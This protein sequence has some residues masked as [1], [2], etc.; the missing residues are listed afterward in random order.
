MKQRTQEWSGAW[1]L[2]V[3]SVLV[4]CARTALTA[5]DLSF[6]S[7]DTF[8]YSGVTSGEQS[9]LLV[10]FS[11][12]EDLTATHPELRGP[13]TL[14]AVHET[15]A[16]EI[17]EGTSVAGEYDNLVSGLTLVKLPAGVSATEAMLQF[18]GSE[19]VLYAEPD[20]RYQL[21]RVPND[22][23]FKDQWNLNNTGQDGGLVDADIDAPEAWDMQT[24]KKSVIVAILDTGIDANNVDVVYNLWSNNKEVMGQPGVDDDGNGK[25]DDFAGYNFLT[26]SAAAKDLMDDAYHGT[27]VAGIIGAFTN[28]SRGIAGTCWQVSMMPLKVGDANGVN[29]SAAV[30]AIEYAVASG[31]RIINASWASTEYS[32]SLRNAIEEAGKKGVLVVAAAGNGSRNIDRLP[33]Y[34]ACYGLYNIISVLATNNRDQLASTSNYGRASVDLG[35]PGEGVLSTTPTVETPAMKA[36]GVTKNYSKLSGTSVAAP[37]V[38]AASALLWSQF[39][40]LSYYHV[41]HILMSTA[42]PVLPGLCLSQGRLNLARALKAVPQGQVGRVINTRNPSSFYFS[43]QQAIDEA[44]DGD[45]IVAE[46]KLGSTSIYPEH[47]DFKG[48]AI[49][50]RSGNPLAPDDPTIYPETTLIYGLFGEG[51]AVTFASGEGRGSVLKGF[52]VGWAM[53]VNGAGIRIEG[54]SPTI[55]QCIISNNQ[56]SDYG[57]GI[58]CFVGSPEITNCVISDNVAFGEFGVGGGL[59]FEQSEASISDCIIRN[60][61]SMNVGGGVGCLDASPTFVNCFV[62]NNAAINGSGQ[63]DLVRAS[64]TITNCTIAVDKNS[65]ARDGGI[66]AFDGS[67]PTI[68]NCILWGNGDDLVG[69]S[70]TYSCIEDID[71]V[72][73]GNIF[74]DPQFVKGPRGTYYL[75]Q[76]EAG[77]LTTSPCVD[78]GDPNTAAPIAQ[79]LHGLTTRTDGVMDTGIIDMGVHYAAGSAQSFPLTVTVVDANDQPVDA[80]EA[81]GSVSPSSGLFREYEVVQLTAQV[82]DGYRIKRWVGIGD[83]TIKDPN[84]LITVT[85][86]MDIKIEFEK[87]PVYHLITKV[88]SRNGSLQP[89]YHRVAGLYPEGTVVD[90]TASPEPTY[91]VDKWQGTDN[92]KSW[93]NDNTVTMTGDKVVTVS[94]RQGRSL[95]VPG[96]YKTIKQAIDAA[97]THGDKIIV[98]GGTYQIDYTADPSGLD[99]KGKAIVL[100]SENP[101]DPYTV[102]HTIIDCN[103]RGRAFIFQNSEGPDAVIQGFTIRNGRTNGQVIRAPGRSGADGADAF[104]GAIACFKGSSPTL[105]NLVVENCVAQGQTGADANTPIPA[106]QA[107]AAP[108]APPDPLDPNDAPVL[109]PDDPNVVAD[110]NAP[111]LNGLPGLEGQVGAT[112]ADGAA[113]A[114]AAK[115]GRGGHGYGGSFYFDANSAPLILHCTFTDDQAIG[116]DGGFGGVGQNGQDGQAGGD[117]QGGQDGQPG[118]ESLGDGPGGNGGNGGNGGAGGNGGKGGD[119]GRGGDGG[120]GGEALGGTLYFGP[121]CRPVIKSCTI[122]NSLVQQGTGNYGGAGGAGGAGGDNGS[123][124]EPGEG[125]GGSGDGQDGQAGQPGADGVGGAGGRGGDG[126]NMGKNG[127]RSWGGAI[128]F[129]DDCQVEISDTTIV[130]SVARVGDVGED[131]ARS[132]AGGTGGS[133]GAGGSTGGAGGDGGNGGNG[134]PAGAPGSGGAGG[135]GGSSGGLGQAGTGTISIPANFGGAIAYRPNC[136]ATLTNCTINNNLVTDNAGG[137]EFYSEGCQTELVSCNIRDNQAGT[138][139]GGQAFDP[140]CTIKITG[141]TYWGNTAGYEANNVP[142]VGDGGGLYIWH[143]CQLDINDTTFTSNR[144]I[145]TIGAGG[146]LYGGGVLDTTLGDWYNGSNVHVQNSFFEDNNAPF[147]GGLYWYGRGATV[148]VFNTVVQNNTAQFGG[149]MYWSN[150][151][152]TIRQCSIRGNAAEGPTETVMVPGVTPVPNDPSTWAPSYLWPDPNDPNSQWDPNYGF[153]PPQ[154]AQTNNLDIGSGGGLFAFSSGALIENC[155]IGENTVRGTGGGVYFSGDPCYPI[156]KNCLIKSNSALIGGGGVTSYW[157]AA[158]TIANCTIVE[159]TASDPNNSGRGEG[160]GLL[161]SYSSQTVLMDSIVWGNSGQSGN[162]IAVGSSSDPAHLQW[163]AALTVEYSDIQGGRSGIA[164][165][166]GR[167]LNWLQGNIAADPLFV[168][169]Y[170]LSQVAAGQDQTSPAVDAGSA[171]AASRGMDQHTTRTDKVGDAGIVDMGFHYVGDGRYQL[172]IQVVGG[173]GWVEPMGGNYHEFQ[174]ITL[175]AHPDDGYRVKQWIGTNNDP[176][177]NTNTNTVTMD[178][179]FKYVTVEFE[180]NKTRNIIVPDEFGTLDEAVAAASPGDTNIILKEGVHSISTITGVDLDGK[181]IRIMSSDPNNPAIVAATIIDCGGSRF[182]R[183]RAFHFQSGETAQCLITG[184]TIRNAYWIG[185]LGANGGGIPQHFIVNDPVYPEIVDPTA[186]APDPTDPERMA[187]GENAAG[188]GYGGAVLCENGS[189]PTFQNVVFEN[190]TVVAAQGGNGLAGLAI[191]QD[192][193]KN[194]YWGG[195]A[196]S[197]SGNGYGGAVACLGGSK[198]TFIHCTFRICLARGG[199]GGDGGAGSN[200]NDGITWASWGGNAGSAYGDG[201][202]GAVYCENGSDA[203]FQDCVFAS[204]GATAGVAGTPG[205]AGPG[206]DLSDPY[207]RDRNNRP[208]PGASGVTITNGTIF[209]GAV[210]QNNA[211]PKFVDC[212]FTDNLAYEGFSIYTGVTTAGTVVDETR[213]YMPGGAIYAGSG[214]TVTLQNCQLLRNVSSAVYAQ[215]RCVLDFNDCLFSRNAADGTNS[216]AVVMGGQ[217]STFN[218]SGGALFAGPYCTQIDLRRCLF[219]SNTA[220][221]D[222]GAL[223]LMSDANITDC[224]FSG[225][226]AD[227]DGGAIDA[228]LDTGDPQTHAILQLDL[229]SCSF[230]GNTALI[231]FYGQGGAVHFADFNAVFTDCYF[232]GNRAKNGGALYLT[233]GNVKMEGGIVNNNESIGGSGVNT[234]A[235]AAAIDPILLVISGLSS[236]GAVQAFQ[237]GAGVDMGGGIVCSGT[238]A[239]IENVTFQNNMAGGVKGSGGAIMLYGGYV[240]HVV[241]NCLFTGNKANHSGAAIWAGLFASPVIKNS[242]F[243]ENIATQRGGALFCDWGS[244]AKAIDSIFQKNGAGAI[245]EMAQENGDNSIVTHSLFA[246]NTGGDYGVYDEKTQ[247][248]QIL[249]GADLDVTNLNADPLFVDGPLGTVYLSQTDAGQSVTSPA[250]DAGSALADDLGLGGRTTRT[251]GA[252][253]TGVVDIGYHFLDH[254]TLQKYRLTAEV[255]GG[256]GTISPTSGEFYAGTPVPLTASPESGWR[257]AQWAGTSDDTSRSVRNLVVMG[258][259][260]HVTLEFDQP[261]TYV[262]GDDPNYT[263]IQHAIDAAVDGDVVVIP[264]GSYTPAFPWPDIII[265][266]KNITLTGPNPDDPNVVANTVLHRYAFYIYNVGPET[267]I[268]GITIADTNVSGGNGGSSGGHDGSPGGSVVGGGMYISNASPTIRNC[269][270]RNLHATGGNGGNGAGGSQ[271][272]PWGYDGGWGGAAYGGA[273]Y[274][275]YLSDPTFQNCAF[276]GCSARGGN[277]GN[278]GNGTPNNQGGRGGSWEWSDYFE[279]Q[280]ILMGWDGWEYG[281]FADY[282]KYSGY[283]GAVCCSYYASPKFVDCL[284][285]DNH[286]YGGVCGIGGTLVRSPDRN[287]NIE[288][289]GGAVYVGVGGNPEFTDCVFRNNSADA[290]VVS[291]PDDVYVS[292]GGSIAFEDGC[293]VKFT[294]CTVQE[295]SACIGGGLWWSNASTEMTDCNIAG[296]MAYH[297]GGMY[298]VDSTGVVAGATVARNRAFTSVIDPN[299]VLDPNFSDIFSW[300]GGYACINSTVEI[301]DSIF[302]D[303]RAVSSGGGVYFGGSDQS[304]TSSPAIRNSLVRGNSAG[305]DGGGIAV[306]WYAEPTIANCTIVENIVTGTFGIAYGGGLAGT[307]DSNTVVTDSIFWGNNSNYLGSEIAATGGYKYGARPATIRVTYSDVQPDFDPNTSDRKPLDIVFL[308]DSTGSM[309]DD[310]DAVKASAA[311]IMD[312]IA[313]TVPDYRVAVADYR[314]FNEDPYGETTDYPLRVRTPFT[315]SADLAIQAI[316][317]IQVAG[318]GDFPESV[319]YALT[320]MIDG[321]LLVG[322]D[323]QSW[324]PGEVDRVILL[325]GD[326]PPHDPEPFTNLTMVNVV[327]MASQTPD[328][329]IFPVQV[330]NEPVTA[331]YFRNL[332]GGTAGPMLQVVDANGVVDAIMTSINLIAGGAPSIHVDPGAKIPGWDAAARTW[333][334]NNHNMSEDPLFVAGYYLSQLASGQTEQSPAVDAGSNTAGAVGLADR[335]TRTDGVGDANIVDM[336]Y[337]YAQGLVQYRVTVTIRPD[338]NTGEIHGTVD[339]MMATVY[340]GFGSV[341]V[342]L[343]ATPDEGYKVKRWIGT[344]DDKST[345]SENDVTLTKDTEVIV[346]FGPAELF[347]YTGIVIDRGDGPHGTLEPQSRQYY[348][349]TKIQL[350]AIPD[351]N[352]VVRQWIGTDN[353]SLRDPNNTVTIDGSDVQVF[354][355]FGRVGQN[356]INLYNEFGLL[357]RRSPFLTIQSAINA[358]GPNN[359]IVL[360]DGVYSGPGN[361]N[362]NLRAGLDVNDVRWL[363][364][365]SENG[366]NDCII[367]VMGLG[368]GFIF[369]SNEDPNY[370][371][372]GLTIRNGRAA[373][374]GAILIDAASPTIDNCRILNSQATGNG[375][376]IWCANGSPIIKSTWISGNIAGGYGGGF[377]GENEAT[378][379]LVNC[380]ITLNQSGDIGGSIFLNNSDATITLCTIAYNYGLAYLNATG[381]TGNNLPKGGVT[382]RDSDPAITDCIIGRNGSLSMDPLYG[383]WGELNGQGDDLYGCGA[384][385]SDIENGDDGDGNINTDPLWI[386]GPLGQFYLSQINSGQLQDSPCIDAG[387]QFILQ[388][389]EDTYDVNQI[390]TNILSTPDTGYGDMGYHYPIYSGPPIQYKLTISVIGPGRVTFTDYPMY[391]EIIDFNDPNSFMSVT[392]TVGPN[393]SPFEHFFSPSEIVNLTAVAD[394][395]YRLLKWQGTDA[396]GILSKTNVVTMDSHKTVIVYFEKKVPRTLTV[397]NGYP[398]IQA[399]VDAARDGDTVVVDPGRYYGNY[400]YRETAS[401]VTLVIDKSITITS[402]DPHD[403]R[404]VESTIIDGFSAISQYPNMGVVFTANTDKDTVLNGFTIENCGGSTGS[405]Q[406]GNRQRN[407][408]NGYDGAPNDGAAIYIEGGQPVIKNCLIRDNQCIGGNGGN[409][410][411]A[412]DSH[413]AGRGGWGG[414]AR[415]AG[416]YVAPLSGPKF[417]NCRFVNNSV[418]GGNG[419]D[420]GSYTANG[421]TGNYGGNWSAYQGVDI[422]P[423]S[424]RMAAVASN[425][426]EIWQADFTATYI[427]YDPNAINT[428]LLGGYAGD[429]RWYS[430]YGGAVFCDIAS[431]AVFEHCEIIGNRVAGGLSGQGGVMGP[432]GRRFDPMIPYEIPSYGAGVYCAKQTNVKFLGCTFEGNVTSVTTANTAVSQRLDPYVGFGG[433]VAAEGT[434]SVAFADCNFVDNDADTG[435]GL[436]VAD[437]V[438][439]VED[440]N[441]TLNT[442]LRG[443]GFAGIGGSIRIEHCDIRNNSAV[444]DPNDTTDDAVSPEGGGVLCLSTNATILD[445]NVADNRSLGSG[446]G[447]YLRGENATTVDNCLIVNNLAYRDGGG[448]TTVWYATPTLQNCTFSGNASPGVPNEP[449]VNGLGGAV[450]CSY[451]SRCTIIDSILWQNQARAGNEMAVSSGFGLDPRCGKIDISYSDVLSGPNDVW[452]SNGCQFQYGKGIIHQDPLFASGPLGDYYL[453]QLYAGVGQVRQSPCVDAGSTTA[454][455]IGMSQY[456]TRTDSAPDIGIVDIGFHYR[457]LE[458]CKV[459][460]IVRDGVIQFN[461]FAKFALEWLD[462]GCKQANGWCKGADFTFDSRVNAIDLAVF[463][464]CWLVEDTTAPVPNPPVWN[465]K[466]QLTTGG[467]GATMSV[468]EVMD[469]WGWPVE[470]YFDCVYGECHDSGWQSKPSYTDTGLKPGLAYV[471]RVKARDTSPR[472]NETKWSELGSAGTGDRTPPAPAPRIGSVTP[473]PNNP[474]ALVVALVEPSFDLNGVEY[475]F[476]VN[477]VDSPSGHDSGWIRTTTY[478]DVNLAPNTQYCYRVRARDMSASQNMT[479]W[480]DWVCGVTGAGADITAPTPNPAQWDPNGLPAEYWGGSNSL[481][482]WV[483]MAVLPAT[484][485]SG[486]VIQYYFECI[487]ERGF[488]SGWTDQTIYRVKVGPA[489]RGYT[490]RVKAR[491]ASGNETGWSYPPVRQEVRPTQP[492]LPTTNN[493]AGGGGSVP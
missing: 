66:W 60:N 98:L 284:F 61:T 308:I 269:N 279:Q 251:D 128:F 282:W 118:G 290:S 425:L 85:G 333:D 181:N 336:G 54:A 272:H 493:N 115:G 472:L 244:D 435:G 256:H 439:T 81:G 366:P 457:F 465:L 156:L 167:T 193:D 395:G 351:P 268:D 297:G 11:D 224:S 39:P 91:I 166:A 326:A 362:L 197:G 19:N 107:P 120:D 490:W 304:V 3:C 357:D 200:P 129:G 386:N 99:F 82:N 108:P 207:P 334:P 480:S 327:D 103:L 331:A 114:P 175:I 165:Q 192:S 204:N 119:G 311:D 67:N 261:H 344:D 215:S 76:A 330:G 471:Y 187:S 125:G 265:D 184:L 51:S 140:F 403:P 257:V 390:T 153:V 69:A 72:G 302:M 428:L 146:G 131:I 266:G 444:D 150:G 50:V 213:I 475:Y 216:G 396:D 399:A 138:H 230:G 52:T 398:S 337:H 173:N 449:N 340:P 102:A 354:V 134:G 263:T 190:C 222:G 170:Y 235:G 423:F 229:K 369:D 238:G 188:T 312:K 414:W 317:A 450:F 431:S 462:E 38:S 100:T 452:V 307:Y 89:D 413:N 247:H 234:Q 35:E 212:R 289:F 218:Y 163:P 315:N 8:S 123:G 32:E 135:Q 470:Y 358:A 26:D 48:K 245:V 189:S 353:D 303:N 278:G 467:L 29:L 388:T 292:Y 270:F 33:V 438:A 342:H 443:A 227:D 461:D 380:L 378:A 408:P 476:D 111:G 47:I 285:E 489:G 160:G 456:T 142:Y 338:P 427:I 420:G 306:G 199:M 132:Y 377:Y 137:G 367:D 300:G 437:A 319:Y 482:Y 57:A 64:P 485:D 343:T 164:L 426:W 75:S 479:A 130:G 24:G 198:P 185:D 88:S 55:T 34:P 394:P 402:R 404:I 412:D 447:I 254:T 162:Q 434:A 360:S 94:F 341:T 406:G 255:I 451:E 481:D 448:L 324:R 288:N 144:S 305:R 148:D 71:D 381:D 415:G 275:G 474:R 466:P 186:G 44:V 260:R 323:G 392:Y 40:N 298:S 401:A 459:C 329:R 365:R 277:G 243:V 90:L 220:S 267:V 387:E 231:G 174:I 421:G 143:N 454:G 74:S 214:C 87:I 4:L 368:R 320:R 117:G 83:D 484:D 133:G 139:G 295:S 478:T 110:P 273:V 12:V 264:A 1:R 424:T 15:V 258:P 7:W 299:Q 113:G 483:E 86:P 407:H 172:Q 262:V 359:V 240:N 225:N 62:T 219:Y 419:G 17:M 14:R 286:T 430:G 469:G 127:A 182:V 492:P 348:D 183:K 169:S 168:A 151:A 314:D 42:D 126:G 23:N 241:K 370:I 149:G 373:T 105:A 345:K 2:L 28:N 65:L 384:T 391:N 281:P 259:D 328:K 226:K 350:K 283:G 371:I 486:G 239:L 460:D 145:S 410:V 84:I 73:T 429:Y 356:I 418:R 97:A 159:N 22:P 80:N 92:D 176:A 221:V 372:R 436:Y 383:Q 321:S 397:P 389:V 313:Q 296:N 393:D 18:A 316:D 201:Q 56:A 223:R 432:S 405:G 77:Q 53:A 6:S 210:R 10:R 233:T 161:C 237:Q 442:A 58:D 180:L 416:A 37:H 147:G 49:T 232:F 376:G 205:A 464:E 9:E 45:E 36:D 211:S 25:V 13:R 374:G 191:V 433:G 309:F 106:P 409:G 209:G 236:S 287:L 363:T 422:D 455:G 440:C 171:S 441:I 157:F 249:A 274:V 101:T 253:D 96:Q 339:P 379:V 446:G 294:R 208:G 21:Q 30:A 124:G 27:Y 271:S 217:S 20:Y 477:E 109:S 242:T 364:I 252:G 335:T 352:Y 116:G 361:Y 332:A 141:C 487:D 325:M 280:W 194:G 385:F 468:K 121:N 291:V 79:R 246:D 112:G 293:H 63:F 355:E 155:I 347:S 104:G 59:N 445:C 78:A 417:I 322:A 206:N 228:Y 400:T 158:P 248:T 196:G 488:S 491:D 453:E 310:I 203:L 154:V 195:H 5:D 43:I 458:P 318:G 202:G 93:A 301:R 31:A 152:P 16:N 473:A 178:T 250:V 411:G 46:G 463:A 136:K 179:S 95:V 68:T 382:C 122:T 349:G 375:G 70:A 346:E 41:K 276:T 177:W